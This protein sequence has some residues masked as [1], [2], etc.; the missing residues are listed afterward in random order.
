MRRTIEFWFD[1]STTFQWAAVAVLVFI[2][3]AREHILALWGLIFVFYK[4]IFTR[5]VVH[6]DCDEFLS[7]F[8]G[9]NLGSKPRNVNNNNKQRNYNRRQGLLYGLGS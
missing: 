7:M 2:G 4:K 6:A 8:R 1:L 3:G 9:S 5:P